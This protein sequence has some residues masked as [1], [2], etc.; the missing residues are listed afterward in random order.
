MIERGERLR[1]L[2]KPRLDLAVRGELGR[3]DLQRDLL[4]GHLVARLVDD[5]HAALPEHV[6]ELVHAEHDLTDH[7]M[8]AGRAERGA[9]AART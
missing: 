1:L 8:R 7:A 9:A 4:L 2:E 6:D 5:A 3:Q